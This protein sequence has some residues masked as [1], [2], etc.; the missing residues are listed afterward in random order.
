MR[1]THFVTT[2]L[3]FLFP[4]ILI[5]QEEEKNGVQSEEVK[6]T[7]LIDGTLLLPTTDE[8]VPLAIIIAGSGPTDRNGNQPMMNNNSLKLL[9]EAL[10]ADSIATFRYDKRIVKQ[11]M[12]RQI[13]E[14]KVRFDHFIDDAIAIIHHFKEDPRFS[15]IY[16]L[17]HSQGSLIGM[18][19]SQNNRVDGFVS[20]AGSGQSIDKIII[21]QLGF[22]APALQE[23]AIQAFEDLRTKGESRDYNPLLASIFREDI[24]PFMLSWMKYDPAEEIKKLEIP[25]LIINGDKD[26]QVQVSE[27]EQLHSLSPDARLMIVP[28]MNHVLK[29]VEDMG[30]ENQKSYNQPDLPIVQELI[31]GITK[32]INPEK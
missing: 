32:F 8:P 3:F 4:I 11:I 24:Q 12:M 21:E 31:E 16:I 30:L 22:Q 10:T 13:D 28:D 2:V 6:I 25:M 23:N 5:A 7:P 19:A 9:A 20:I 29:K 15:S 18:V 27:A 1:I 14:S 17:G 26:I